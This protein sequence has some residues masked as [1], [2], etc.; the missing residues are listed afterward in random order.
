MK[1]N[2][3][4]RMIVYEFQRCQGQCKEVV[5]RISGQGVAEG[6]VLHGAKSRQ[7][8]EG[9]HLVDAPWFQFHHSKDTEQWEHD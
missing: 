7:H 5:I 4:M 1:K 9:S 8:S 3:G 6:T 2:R